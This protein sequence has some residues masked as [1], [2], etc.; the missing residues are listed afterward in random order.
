[1]TGL[2]D[3]SSEL[4]KSIETIS[5]GMDDSITYSLNSLIFNSFDLNS[6]LENKLYSKNQIRIGTIKKFIANSSCRLTFNFFYPLLSMFDGMNT[7]KINNVEFNHVHFEWQ[8]P[9]TFASPIDVMLISEQSRVVY[10][11]ECKY[12]EPLSIN[13][14]EF[15]NSYFEMYKD[16]KHDS[17]INL[18]RP[19]VESHRE[20]CLKMNVLYGSGI[21]QNLRQIMTLLISPN[22]F[23]IQ[24]CNP[25]SRMILSKHP[26]INE[27]DIW[28]GNLLFYDGQSDN[29]ASEYYHH[30]LSFSHTVK[31]QLYE[32]GI[33]IQNPITYQEIFESNRETYQMEKSGMKLAEYL[34]HHYYK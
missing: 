4:I 7:L 24:Q 9:K 34:N 3:S 30:C 19:L 23:M 29:Q 21:S 8:P 16:Q 22:L 20:L 15:S 26:D 33:M 31:D 14:F 32:K 2:Q 18:I 25:T 12:Q 28:F 13:P 5:A 11:L 6:I 27:Y 10:F 17:V 1:M